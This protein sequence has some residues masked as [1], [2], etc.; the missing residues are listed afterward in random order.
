[1]S[2]D[3]ISVPLARLRKR[4]PAQ[5]PTLLRE[6]PWQLRVREAKRSTLTALRLAQ[7][8]LRPTL[9]AEPT[10]ARTH[11][12]PCTSIEERVALDRSDPHAEPAFERGKR[13]N[14][15]LAA[16]A[17]DGVA[18]EPGRV[19]SFWRTLGPALA[20]RGFVAG[21][22]LRGGCIL[23]S[24]GGGLCLLSNALFRLALRA[25]F[26]IVERHGHSL[27]AVPLA[28]GELWGADA[29]VAF[30]HI[31]LR[32][33]PR[34]GSW[35]LRANVTDTHLALTLES[36]CVPSHAVEL[37]NESLSIERD[38]SGT[39]RTGA[40]VRRRTDRRGAVHTEL[41]ARDRKRV[42]AAHELGR[43]CITCNETSCHAREEQLALLSSSQR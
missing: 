37:C 14:V 27:E 38:A 22:E 5:R 32:F 9:F 13:H 31:D 36:D 11:A 24:I 20:S 33:A 17:F 7:W 2:A 41:V 12:A 25:D 43:N 21:M 8:T 19:F 30:A 28:E 18:L 4:G 35:V 40:L 6:S 29:T 10:L 39:I 3:E 16:S 34:E 1:M 15:R 26:V 42:L 23:P